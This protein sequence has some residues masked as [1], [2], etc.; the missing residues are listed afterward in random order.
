MQHLLFSNSI[1][2]G[3]NG[4]VL[5]NGLRY[6]TPLLIIVFLRIKDVLLIFRAAETIPIWPGKILTLFWQLLV[7]KSAVYRAYLW[8]NIAMQKGVPMM[9][10]L[11]K[12][13]KDIQ[14]HKLKL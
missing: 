2:V 3:F 5:S 4:Y 9:F 14:S 13:C 10:F 1:S 11:S 12:C 7:W 8:H 6:V